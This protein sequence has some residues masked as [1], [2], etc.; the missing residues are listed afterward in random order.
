VSFAA[1]KP[2]RDKVRDEPCIV[3][4]RGPCDPSHLAARA[5]GGCDHPDCVVPMCR[6]CHSAFD[7]R[8][9]DVLPALL[10]A[11]LVPEI[12]HAVGHYQG[13]LLGLLH[14]LTGERFAPEERRA[15]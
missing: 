13:N 1:S 11:K 12:Q 4:R 7:T 14:R 9:L 5:K 6:A 10:A 15:A 8:R 2:Q 3:C